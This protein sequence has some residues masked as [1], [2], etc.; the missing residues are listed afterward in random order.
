MENIQHKEFLE[1][2]NPI[3]LQLSNYC[4]AISG[5]KD[6]AKD[7]LSD[8]VLNILESFAR[9]KDKS[10]FRSYAFTIASNLHKKKIRQLKFRAEFSDT[11]SNCIVDHSQDQEYFTDFELIYKLILSLPDRIAETIILFHI[12]DLSIQEI[13]RIQ[14]G[15]ISGV[16]QRLKR[17]REKLMSQIKEP[18][19]LKMAVLF[20]TL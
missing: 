18:D 1:L 13:R 9:I 11:E 8:T 17:G 5:N 14:G 7:L 19:Q 10:A 16:K 4:R 3:H 20:F 6:D 15:S 2:Y 12:S